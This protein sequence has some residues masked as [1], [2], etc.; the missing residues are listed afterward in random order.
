MSDKEATTGDVKLYRE[1]P[2]CCI[3]RVIDTPDYPEMWLYKLKILAILNGRDF[4]KAGEDFSVSRTKG[5]GGCMASW[6]LFEI[7]SEYAKDWLKRCNVDLASV[8]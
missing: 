2:L 5:D 4:G 8:I 6:C 3:V 7:D 1:R